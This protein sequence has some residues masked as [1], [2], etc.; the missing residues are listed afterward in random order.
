METVT[1]SKDKL[2]LVISDVEKLVSH[3][4][5][6]VEDQEQIIKL[7]L[8]DIKTGKIKGVSEEELDKYLEKRGVKVA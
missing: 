2:G 5:D 1:V 6:L 8:S 4:E 7:R 3:F